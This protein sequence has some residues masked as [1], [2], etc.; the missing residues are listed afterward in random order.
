MS[1]K[2][3]QVR[4]VQGIVTAGKQAPPVSEAAPGLEKRD[5]C[6]YDNPINAIIGSVKMV[7]VALRERIEHGCSSILSVVEKTQNNIHPSTTISALAFPGSSSWS[8]ALFASSWLT[9]ALSH[10]RSRQEEY[11][12]DKR[13]FGCAVSAPLFQGEVPGK[14]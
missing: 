10:E 5:I 12:T 14:A 7:C 1:G 13:S 8:F 4:V 2:P 11:G 9:P 6:P 3:H